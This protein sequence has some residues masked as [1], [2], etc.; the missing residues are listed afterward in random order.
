MDVSEIK[1]ST[2]KLKKDNEKVAS[3]IK[4]MRDHLDKIT[5]SRNRL[6][7][8]WEGQAKEAF[9]KAYDDDRKF[10]ETVLKDIDGA[11]KFEA[12]AIAAYEACENAITSLVASVKI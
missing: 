5:D 9:S 12:G 6:D 8:M 10:A 4:S 2:T 1:V 11:R 7:R 3:L